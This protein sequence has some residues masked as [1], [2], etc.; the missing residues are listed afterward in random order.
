MVVAQC[1]LIWRIASALFQFL[2]GT[3]CDLPGASR[4]LTDL[5][6]GAWLGATLLQFSV[7]IGAADL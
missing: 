7:S 1:A 2:A 3:I 6:C 5:S 4:W